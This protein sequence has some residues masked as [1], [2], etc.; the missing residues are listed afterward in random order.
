MIY[1]KR[2]ILPETYTGISFNDQGVCNFCVEYEPYHANIGKEN[3]IQKIHHE[4]EPPKYHCVVPLSGGKDSTYILYYAVKELNLKPIAVNYES[5]FQTDL[6]KNN[7]ENACK[8][9]G[10]PLVVEK[11]PGNIQTKLLKES[12]LVSQ[13]VGYL[14]HFCGNCE[15]ILRHVSISTARTH[16]VPFIFWGSSSLENLRREYYESYRNAKTN[17]HHKAL[18]LLTKAG[19]KAKM[20]LNN[21]KKI[22]RIPQNLYPYVGYHS[23]KYRVFSI[24]QRAKMNLPL[25]YAVRPYSIPEFTKTNP[26]FIHFFDY[27]SWDSVSTTE[28][29]KRELNWKHPKN[30]ISRFDCLIHCFDNY[31]YLKLYGIS[32]DGITFCNF[33]R[34]NTMKREEA[35]ARE[36][37]IIEMV[38]REC[39]HVIKMIGLRKYVVP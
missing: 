7:M 25:R 15:A 28:V 17:I 27:I 16:Q 34:E 30:K 33:I 38:E 11:S 23:L 12:L 36:N 8:I 19:S 14:T 22:V 31:K 2:C 4:K 37:D 3:L 20:L 29:L 6:A 39:E 13:K 18:A 35:M 21:P 9:L 5:G 24:L 32:S 10:V 26:E 1:C